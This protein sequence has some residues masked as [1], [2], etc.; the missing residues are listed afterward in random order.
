MA[1]STLITWECRTAG[2]DNS[3]GGFKRGAT[4]TDRSQQNAAYVSGTNLTV[5]AVTNT[6]VLPDGHTP[7]AADVGNLIQITAGAGFTLG[8][9]EIASIQSGYWRLD[10]SPAAV[11][12]TSGIWAMGGALAS[13]SIAVIKATGN[14]FIYIKN[15]G[16]YSITS[17]SAGVA[18]GILQTASNGSI[19]TF[20]R[21]IGY[22]TTRNEA[23]LEAD[24]PVIQA[25][26]ISTAILIDINH[27]YWLVTNIKVD[28]ASL[29]AISGIDGTVSN[30]N[31]IINC[32]VLNCTTVGIYLN[33]NAGYVIRCK[34]Y[35]CSGTYAIYG[36]VGVFYCESFD[37]TVTGIISNYIFK[38]ISYRNRGA[39]VRGIQTILNSTNIC[40]GNICFYN[41]GDGIYVP[42]SGVIINNILYNN[43]AYGINF[44]NYSAFSVNN[45]FGSNT[46]GET[47]GSGIP[48]V[49]NNVTLIADPFTSASTSTSG[50]SDF[51][52]N[53]TAGGGAAC[54]NVGFPT[55]SIAS[56][57]TF[58]D[59]GYSRHQDPA[60]GGS[61]AIDIH[62][63]LLVVP[64][65]VLAY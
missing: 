35:G 38:C 40:I 51:S 28:G 64:R 52:L 14:N 29:T 18:G 37:N 45:A 39:N 25:S 56:T 4:G 57:D 43:G 53:A 5:H 62:N 36:G 10:R 1:L 41:Q 20:I 17:A 9:Y 12:T 21:I 60:G 61:S 3:G 49:A 65:G 16:V 54:K 26:G 19:T 47:T 59:I 44:A 46:S 24:M 50:A 31:I 32:V 30:Y 34:V 27:S 58:N 13:P 55:E 23:I 2:S 42:G 22:K 48:L 15:D 7:A 33:V 63:T 8:F 6:D 11:G